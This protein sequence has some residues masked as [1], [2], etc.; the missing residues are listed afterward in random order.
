MTGTTGGDVLRRAREQYLSQAV[1]TASR[2]RLV[3]M[4]Y[5]GAL[6]RL[7]RAGRALERGERRDAGEALS[8]ALAIVDELRSTLDFDAGGDVAKELHALY[9]FVV[10]RLSRANVERDPERVREAVSVLARL[11]EGWDGIAAVD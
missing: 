4:L 6:K 7:E 1:M 11:K 5:D 8:S 10:D 9:G 2:E 3:V